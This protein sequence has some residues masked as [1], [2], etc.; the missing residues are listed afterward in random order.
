MLSPYEKVVEFNKAFDYKVHHI[1]EGNALELHP[2]DAKYR[3]N[4]IHEEGIVE[5]GRAIHIN[6]RVET[7]DGV[8]DLLYVLYGACYTYDLNPDIMINSFHENYNEFYNKTKLD[9]LN[10]SLEHSDYYQSLVNNIENVRVCLLEKKNVIELYSV[11]IK[12][13]INTF[14][15]GFSLRININNVFDIVHNSNM[16]KL[17]K[18]EE[19]AKETVTFYDHKYEMYV[20]YYQEFCERFGKNSEQAKDI[21][22][23][24]DSPYYYKSGNYYLVKN[25]STGKALKS[26]NYI[27]VLF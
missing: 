14:Q 23:P 5:L 6:D 10:C 13:I 20:N 27:P 9:V 26:I 7:M 12:T 25:K 11:L 4:L 15:L 17:C 18:S 8:A 21:Y 3:S 2:N 22:S 1:N 19:E 16:S 24:Y